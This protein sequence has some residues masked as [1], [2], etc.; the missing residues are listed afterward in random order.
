MLRMVWTICPISSDCLLT[1][2]MLRAAALRS[3]E[4]SSITCTVCCTTCEPLRAQASFC[5]E[6]AWA[7]SAAVCWV[8]TWRVISLANLTTLYRRPRVSKIGL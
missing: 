7:D 3:W 6:V 8:L 4:I 1:A 5:T 2:S